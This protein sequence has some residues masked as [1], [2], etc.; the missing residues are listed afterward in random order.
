MKF[1]LRVVPDAPPTDDLGQGQ[2]VSST[3]T[4]SASAPIKS[5]GV[6]TVPLPSPPKIQQG[7]SPKQPQNTRREKQASDRP[8]KVRPSMES[9]PV[10]CDICNKI[11]KNRS[12]L[13][14]HK[15]RDHGVKASMQNNKT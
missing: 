9:G 3:S 2:A 15:N 1:D 8:V 10:L 5:Q 13:Y 4:G 12:T 14:S 6:I 11:Y 7:I